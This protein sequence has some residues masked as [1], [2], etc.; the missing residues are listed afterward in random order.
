MNMAICSFCQ[1][2]PFQNLP[3]LPTPWRDGLGLSGI[4]N[5][6]QFHQIIRDTSQSKGSQPLGFLHQPS[7]EALAVSSA[8]CELCALIYESAR[9]FIAAFDI[10]KDDPEFS[11]FYRKNSDIPV[12]LPLWLTRRLDGGDGFLVF[13]YSQS[14][15]NIF[16]IGAV[17][18]CVD[19]DSTLASFFEG[20]PVEIFSRPEKFSNRATSWLHQCLNKHGSC[21]HGENSKLPS[22][23]LDLGYSSSSDQIKL[24]EPGLHHGR[25]ATL[26]H[27]WGHSGHYTTTRNSFES[28]KKGIQL[29]ELPRT[30]LDAVTIARNLS[31]RYLWVDSLCICQDDAEDWERESATMASVYSNSYLTISATGSENNS[32]GMLGARSERRHVSVHCLLEN[33]TSDQ[34][35]A[36]RLPISKA[37]LS[38]AFMEMKDQPLTARAWALQE[39]TMSHRILHFCS[40]Q[41]YYECNEEFRSEDGV[42]IQGRYNALFPGPRPVYAAANRESQHS[43]EHSLW[44][45]VPEDYTSR[46]LTKISDKFPALSGLARLF[47]ARIDAF[48]VAGLWSN[49]LV[50]GLAWEPL[51]G[52]RSDPAIYTAPSW[53]WASY[54]GVV[55]TGSSGWNNLATVLDYNVS[56]KGTNPFGEVANGWIKLQSPLIPLTVSDV[57]DTEERWR[58]RLKTPWR[59]PFGEYANF[60]AIK[61]HE[62]S[63]VLSLSPVFAL[64]LSSFKSVNKQGAEKLTY[65]CLIV[66]D[67]SNDM[68]QMKRLGILLMEDDSLGNRKAVQ[69]L[70]QFPIVTLL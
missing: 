54:N 13:T 44:N 21:H 20:R 14:G 37:L 4:D 23:V 27:C 60:D 57:P 5:L 64:V 26:S 45:R 51:L 33:G 69:E 15:N 47:S 11:Y 3:E 62:E 41:M 42:R 17:G 1:S 22:R 68:K 53:S 58:M 52:N 70:Y 43:E 10:A 18:L 30:F 19:D 63:L 8:S 29:T 40:D 36:F 39:R 59:N 55:A 7:L 46:H 34:V 38:Q 25:Y 49:A 32:A 9:L 61:P 65:K 6:E 16:L 50:E 12:N 56:L 24:W 67:E 48:Y 31:I 66:A 35:F 28:R 2:V